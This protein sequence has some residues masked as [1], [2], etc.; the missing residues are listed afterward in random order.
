MLEVARLNQIKVIYH[1]KGELDLSD[2]RDEAELG[3]SVP[4][5]PDIRALKPR[6]VSSL[7]RRLKTAVRD[8]LT[9]S[10]G[11]D[12]N[13][14]AAFAI[15]KHATHWTRIR[16]LNGGDTVNA[17]EMYCR[18]ERNRARDATFVKFS[19]EVD[20][21]RNFRNLPVELRRCV[22]YGQLLHVLEVEIDFSSISDDGKKW[23][24]LAV[25]R[26][27]RLE[28]KNRLDMPYYYD[29][30]FKP[31]VVVDAD[32]VSCLVARIPDRRPNK[33]LRWALY[34]RPYAMGLG[35]EREV[36]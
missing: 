14:Q 26:P 7:D 4:G 5:Y 23:L 1:L 19:I 29:D 8:H 20:K 33:R 31:V 32:D 2:A 21:N 12:S 10:Y 34:E 13:S 36:E 25:I 18:S 27:C 24:L 17:A 35:S 6:K 9:L 22:A 16:Y 30:H 15:P 28:S 11:F 3:H